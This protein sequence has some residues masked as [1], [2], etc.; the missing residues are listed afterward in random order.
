MSK[1]RALRA[2]VEQRLAAAA[3]EIFGLFETTIAEYEEELGRSREEELGRSRE[4]ELG[5]SR[6]EEL[7]HR[8]EDE[9]HRERR[10]TALGPHLRLHRAVL[11]VDVQ[12]V[13]VIKQEVPPE[14]QEWSS[15]VDQQE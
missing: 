15:I 14:Q 6:K 8:E 12:Q 7:G 5:R 4:E 10:D 11:P 1:G 13:L 2:L 9:G 3:Q